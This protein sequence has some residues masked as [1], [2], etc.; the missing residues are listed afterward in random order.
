MNN[1]EAR[2]TNA[3]EFVPT[4][5]IIGRHEGE[6]DLGISR[7]LSE[8]QNNHSDPVTPICIWI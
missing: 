5:N 8:K 3:H 1:T 6:E 2:A 4:D 7:L